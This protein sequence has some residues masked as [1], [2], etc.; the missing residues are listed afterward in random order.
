MSEN[1]L[2]D[3]KNY[4]DGNDSMKYYYRGPFSDIERII[5]Q[6]LNGVDR[7]HD[8]KD[9]HAKYDAPLSFSYCIPNLRD[10]LIR[11]FNDPDVYDIR[12]MAY[13][14]ATT[15]W[16]SASVVTTNITRPAPQI[17]LVRH[18]EKVI[19]QQLRHFFRYKKVV[20]GTR[21]HT[22]SLLKLVSFQAEKCLL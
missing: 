8:K 5:Y 20:K 16:E 10:V 4:P 14:L 21:S 7:D 12:W 3:I 19:T 18:R 6:F 15:Y 13:M 1:F 22:L 9:L 2:D 11:I 17:L